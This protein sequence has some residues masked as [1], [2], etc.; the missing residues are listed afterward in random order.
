M[1]GIYAIGKGL[2]EVENANYNSQIT[3]ALQGIMLAPTLVTLNQ[4]YMEAIAEDALNY[5][6]DTAASMIGTTDYYD[7]SEDPD[8]HNGTGPHMAAIAAQDNTLK[9][10]H[11]ASADLNI[12][13]VQNILDTI[14]AN[15][16]Y[17][18]QNLDNIFELEAPILQLL[19]Q[20]TSVI[21]EI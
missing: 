12:G 9:D 4:L 15:A 10:L 13:N 8:P 5:A 21:M 6:N 1:G 16:A 19:A 3:V 14:K 17:L 7:Q 11:Q 18:G 2:G 20:T